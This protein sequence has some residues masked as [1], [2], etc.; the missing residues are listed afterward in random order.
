VHKSVGLVAMG[1]VNGPGAYNSANPDN[2]VTLV[3][4]GRDATVV[5]STAT[6]YILDIRNKRHGDGPECAPAQSG[7]SRSVRDAHHRHG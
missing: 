1:V 4:A 7:G 2:T 5:T 3:G 6:G